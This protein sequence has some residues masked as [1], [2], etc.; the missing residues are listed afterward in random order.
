[1]LP[2]V[3]LVKLLLVEPH[4]GTG[5]KTMG[6][7]EAFIAEEERRRAA[8]RNQ[9]GVRKQLGTR[10]GG[11][12]GKDININPSDVDPNIKPGSR[13]DRWVMTPGSGTGIRQ[14]LRGDPSVFTGGAYRAALANAAARHS[15]AGTRPQR[16][17]APQRAAYQA[18]VNQRR[19]QAEEMQRRRMAAPYMGQ[20]MA[21]Q[22]AARAFGN[23]GVGGP[24]MVPLP[25]G[26]IAAPG[27]PGAW[28]RHPANTGAPM[29][30]PAGGS[31]WDHRREMTRRRLEGADAR[32]QEALHQAGRTLSQPWGFGPDIHGGQ[33][34]SSSRPLQP[35]E[36]TEPPRHR[37]PDPFGA[38]Q[39]RD[40]YD[41]LD[42]DYIENMYV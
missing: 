19:A 30:Q 34:V 36:P 26:G 12:I 24:N 11:H 40:P 10:M 37:R 9:A 1:M 25:T 38:I 5:T 13:R 14:Q 29:G 31:Y 32:H 42:E 35:G 4:K 39:G 28:A 16:R 15:G 41:I 7:Q 6:W 23:Q 2:W 27:D 17:H 8:E 18:A 33:G 20:A 3:R 22:Y 21:N